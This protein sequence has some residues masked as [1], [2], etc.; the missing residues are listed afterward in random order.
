LTI[1]HARISKF[2]FGQCKN[3]S[4]YFNTLIELH[5]KPTKNQSG[6]VKKSK[7][8]FVSILEFEFKFIK[9]IISF[10]F[11]SFIRNNVRGGG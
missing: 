1:L 10:S 3:I 4:I 7:I 8:N 2:I 11:N 6:P 5:Y 9:L